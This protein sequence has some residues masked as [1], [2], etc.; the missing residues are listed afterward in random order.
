MQMTQ[1][2]HD[3]LAVVR[4]ML[5]AA[6]RGARGTAYRMLEEHKTVLTPAQ[7][8]ELEEMMRPKK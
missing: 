6:P 1:N 5:T 8:R 2:P 3:R 4:A 7:Q